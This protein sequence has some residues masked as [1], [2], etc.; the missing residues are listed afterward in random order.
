MK[1]ER[2]IN[3]K[4]FVGKILRIVIVVFNN[5]NGIKVNREKIAIS[6]TVLYSAYPATNKES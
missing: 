5:K 6:L 3:N 4:A 2:I 1:H